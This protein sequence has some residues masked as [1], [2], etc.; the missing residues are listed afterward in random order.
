L[1]NQ[2]YPMLSCTQ[3]AK[4]GAHCSPPPSVATANRRAPM[5]SCK[6]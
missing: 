4:P 6:V 1:A 3:F 5:F 2:Y